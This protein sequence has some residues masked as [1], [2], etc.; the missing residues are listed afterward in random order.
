MVRADGV[1]F[2]R[3]EEAWIGDLSG[4]SN[5][6]SLG[7]SGLK[8]RGPGVPVAYCSF[9]PYH[10]LKQRHSKEKSGKMWSRQ[11]RCQGRNTSRRPRKHQDPWTTRGWL[12]SHREILLWG[13]QKHPTHNQP[14][15]KCLSEL[16]GALRETGASPCE[17]MSVGMGEYIHAHLLYFWRT[18]RFASV[19]FGG[20][21]STVHALENW[22]HQGAQPPEGSVLP[23]L[24]EAKEACKALNAADCHLW[25]R[26][27]P[28]K[29][30]ALADDIIIVP[31]MYIMLD[32]VHSSSVYHLIVCW[33]Q[34]REVNN[35][36][37]R[38]C[39]KNKKAEAQSDLMTY[40]SSHG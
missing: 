39:F 16:P 11:K 33:Q 40:S 37:Y 25:G 35:W 38:P 30:Q 27:P 3:E 23:S 2:P 13:P 31:S 10:K 34:P 28:I 5:W 7:K 29:T 26:K 8:L 20:N 15:P 22:G 4:I 36:Y 12:P 17:H 32:S 1:P 24:L 6:L 19:L 18:D 14:S 9:T 21:R